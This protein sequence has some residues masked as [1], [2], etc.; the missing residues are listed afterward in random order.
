VLK[1][2]RSDRRGVAAVEF[3]LIAPA[4]ILLYCGM[5]EITLT[6]M[7]GRRAGHAVS[8]VGDLVA[9]S[10]QITSAQMTDIF[11]VADAIL[12]PFP[13]TDLKMRVSSVTADVAA[14]PK[15]VWSQGK[16]MTALGVG[17]TATAVPAGLMLAGDN[18]VM[19]EMSYTYTPPLGYF[20][21]TGHTFN[22]TFLLRP[23][24]TPQVAYTP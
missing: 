4:M 20:I 21:K 22:Q 14:V 8:A 15:V 18:V 17:V 9:Q 3:A 1:W 12:E 13:T 19:A 11:R 24:R 16:G 10:S 5:A 2:F 6:L 23:R 7:A